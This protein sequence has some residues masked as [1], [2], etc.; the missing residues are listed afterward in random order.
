M[1]ARLAEDSHHLGEER[2]HAGAHVEGRHRQPQGI[3]PNHPSHSRSQ[4]P[5]AAAEDAGTPTPTPPCG[6]CRQVLAEF[7]TGLSVV[8]PGD[9][10]DVKPLSAYLPHGFGPGDFTVGLFQLHPA[11]VAEQRLAE[12]QAG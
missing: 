2:I 7:G 4:A 3:D 11:I 9:P 10:A 12:V 5:Q 8:L 6:A 1:G